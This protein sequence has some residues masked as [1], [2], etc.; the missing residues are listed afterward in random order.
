MQKGPWLSGDQFVSLLDLDLISK[1]SQVD[2]PESQQRRTANV[3]MHGQQLV[4]YVSWL[5][6]TRIKF[7]RRPVGM[8]RPSLG[9][10]AGVEK[11]VSGAL[12]QLLSYPP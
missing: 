2:T 9:G 12:Y 7:L 6:V 8:K 11:R 1:G 5:H 3:W 4:S 10:H